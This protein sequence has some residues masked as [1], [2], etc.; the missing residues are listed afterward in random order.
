MRALITGAAD[1]SGARWPIGSSPTGTRL[2]LRRLLHGRREFVAEALRND[3]YR[4]VEGDILDADKLGAA[5][6]G[7]DVVFHFAAKRTCGAASS[8]RAMTSEQ[9]TIGTF[10]LL[11]AMSRQGV[12]SIAFSS[13]GSVYGE[14][15]VFP[16]P[17]DCPFPL[18]TSLYGASKLAGEGLISAYC[19]GF[20]FSGWVF[21]FV[22]I[23]GER[24]THGHVF[25]FYRQ[26]RSDPRRLRILGN[27][28]QRKSYLYVQDC[29][30]AMLHAMRAA[31][32]GVSRLQ[33]RDG[34]VRHRQRLG[35]GD[36][37]AARPR[38]KT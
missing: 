24:Y 5:L 7:H 36:H 31:P 8:T 33:S 21:R 3:R 12:K 17:E 23:L 29:V 35:G 25:D 9:N 15:R 16:T 34:R 22:S 14:P 13:T 10:T 27:G 11:E 26:L 30:E 2:R 6:R 18:Q 38:T 37:P 28:L 1:S 19:E 32:A 20:G 4:L